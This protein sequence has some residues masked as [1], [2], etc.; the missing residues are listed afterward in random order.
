MSIHPVRRV[1]ETVGAGAR[2]AVRGAA[3]GALA[4]GVAGY[5]THG[6]VGALVGA[7]G[8]AAGAGPL[9]AANHM[10]NKHRELSA[11]IAAAKADKQRHIAGLH[12]RAQRFTTAMQLHNAQF[13]AK[14]RRVH[15]RFA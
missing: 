8:G 15:G 1:A 2:G 10:L 3:L 11:A 9:N 4:G 5:H 7:M 6:P 13:E 14:H 12:R